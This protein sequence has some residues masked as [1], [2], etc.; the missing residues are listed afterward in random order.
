MEIDRQT[1]IKVLEA[2]V[3]ASEVLQRELMLHQM[4]FSAACKTKGLTEEETQKAVDRGRIAS[5]ERIKASCQAN[6]QS[7]LAKL[8]QLVDLL[9][10][11]QDAALRFLK[12][13]TPK[14]PPN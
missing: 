2:F 1:L 3:D 5:T 7:L 6:Y 10:S 4:L 13:W 8:P 11:D 14:D 12:E 9:A